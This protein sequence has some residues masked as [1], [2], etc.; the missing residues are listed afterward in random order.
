VTSKNKTGKGQVQPDVRARTLRQY[1][2][3][4]YPLS[5]KDAGWLKAYEAA[6]AKRQ[7]TKATRGAKALE[8]AEQAAKKEGRV[9]SLVDLQASMTPASPSTRGRTVRLDRVAD[10][11]GRLAVAI[12]NH[13]VE[14]LAVATALAFGSLPRTPENKEVRRLARMGAERWVV[15]TYAP[16]KK[17]GG[18]IMYGSD[19]LALIALTEMSRQGATRLEFDSMAD[20]LNALDGTK[21][22][23]QGGKQK[24]LAMQRLRRVR[25]TA[26]T[27]S[28]Y[29]SEA[30]AR[31][32][33]NEYRE[34]D[35]TLIHDYW[36]PMREEAR[37]E[38]PLFQPWLELSPAFLAYTAERDALTYL[39][40]DLVHAFIGHPLKLQ[41]AMWLY[42]RAMA[43]RSITRGPMDAL[44]EQCGEGREPRKLIRDL[45]VALTE[46]LEFY[47]ATGR[48]LH[49]RF[50]EGPD[51]PSENPKGGRPRKVWHLEVGQ[52]D[53]LSGGLP[54]LKG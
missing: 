32:E 3:W 18:G 21:G 51:A 23:R 31:A 2:D 54:V 34:L 53:K 28:F 29:T 43:A 41:F 35:V 49:A 46:I 38:K 1:L 25:N 17:H 42:P 33:V 22:E 37:G 20:L 5:P 26:I 14:S 16:K 45:Q 27:I 50:V 4:G 19:S 30:D 8:K 24:M 39:P 6:E 13:E 48:R 40:T 7:R 36:N 15:V 11:A 44:V 52:S 12:Q 10:H 9:A 47:E